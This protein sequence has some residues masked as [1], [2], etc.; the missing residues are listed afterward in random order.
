MRTL[1]IVPG[2]FGTALRCPD[3]GPIWG[4]FR[5]LYGGPLIGELPAPRGRADGVLHAIRLGPLVLYDIHGALLRALGRAGYTL[6]KDLFLY[7]YDWR[8]R[9]VD[10]GPPLAAEI[11]RLA[12]ASGGPID[13]L[14]LSNGG[15]TLRAAFVVDRALPVERV[16]L[17]G[18]PLAGSVETLTVLHAG[19]QFAP[20]GRTVSPEEFVSCPGAMDSIPSPATASFMDPDG[21]AHDLYDLATWRRLRLSVFRDDP[22]RAGWVE[23]VGKRLGDLRETWRFLEDAAVPKHLT[24]VCGDGLPTQRHILVEGGR[25]RLPG[26]G[27]LRGLPAAAIVEGDGTVTLESARSWAGARPHVIKIPVSRHRDV[28]R[29]PKALAAMLEGLR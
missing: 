2:L 20:L 19:F 15:L 29:S 17:S 28:V 5:C 18:P 21:G 6:G 25:V 4:P 16:V 14:G 13:L 27:N 10:E 9:V 7:G 11:R 26:E 24:C 1:L 12:E 3:Q 8:Q 23:A 22:D